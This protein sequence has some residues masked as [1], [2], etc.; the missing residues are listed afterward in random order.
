MKRISRKQV[1]IATLVLALVAAAV[2]AAVV[3]RGG[4]EAQREVRIL[5]GNP[6]VGRAFGLFQDETD[7]SCVTG[8][9]RDPWTN[10]EI[11]FC[12]G[13][14]TN[15]TRAPCRP[16][17]WDGHKVAYPSKWATPVDN[18]MGQLTC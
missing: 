3:A 16:A 1:V 15:G 4:H 5:G 2:G 14:Y 10:N 11:Y 7:V 12:T 17:V 18:G 9:S 8:N 13:T 6:T